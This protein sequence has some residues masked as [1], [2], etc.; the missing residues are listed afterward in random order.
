MTFQPKI[1]TK[2]ARF[3]ET[4]AAGDNDDPLAAIEAALDERDGA[5]KSRFTDLETKL[6][7]AV[8]RADHLETA[9]K[10][11]GTGSDEPKGPTLEEKAFSAF[12][13]T[14]PDGLPEVERKSLTVGDNTAGGYLVTS[15]FE[16][17]II[18]NLVEFSPIR[19]A[20]RVGQMTAGEILIPRRT[21]A[22]TAY[23]VGETEARTG[24]QQAYGQARITAHESACYID[25][26][27][28][29]LEDAGFSVEEEIAMD[30]AE[31]FGRLEGYSFVL[32]NGVNKPFGILSDA[33][34]TS[35]V[36]GAATTV[37][38]DGLI[39]I[40]YNLPAPYRNKSTW[41]MNGTTLGAVRKLKDGNGQYLWMP[42]IAAGQPETI[43]GRPVVEAVD[44]P[45]VGAGLTPIAVGDFKQAYRIYDRVGMSIL[46][47]PYTMA[48]S[49][50]VR[51]HARG[52]VA[53]DVVKAEALRKMTISA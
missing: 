43:L 52:R 10:R 25:V 23:W 9:F 48:T 36:S 50:L 7:Q 41:M 44:M 3:L 31:E 26:S 46:R 22:P 53:G 20:A 27:S 18:K 24:T 14:G 2:S 33:G 19:Q 45:D 16:K 40:L 30:L 49:G 21:A 39:N 13:R 35:V 6:A 34:V 47:D 38:A 28:K 4:K 32:G 1:E 17:E 37:T 51:F 8:E 29:L 15:Q 11:H 12:L 42:G 5:V